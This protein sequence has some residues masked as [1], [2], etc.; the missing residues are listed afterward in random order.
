MSFM[1]K[2][3]HKIKENELHDFNYFKAI[4]GMLDGI[5][6]AGSFRLLRQC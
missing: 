2:K 3:R 1:S 4:A 6:Q 5:H